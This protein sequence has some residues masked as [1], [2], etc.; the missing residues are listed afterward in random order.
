M[1]TY[2]LF[3]SKISLVALLSMGVVGTACS[4]KITCGEGTSLDGKECVAEEDGAG[5]AGG[6]GS[7][8]VRS[9]GEVTERA[10]DIETVSIEFEGAITAAPSSNTS[11]VVIWGEVSVPDTTF[12]IYVARSEDGFSFSNPQFTAPAGAISFE[13]TGLEKGLPHFIIVRAVIDGTEIENAKTVSVTPEND[14]EAPSFAGI[15]STSSTDG[16]R[17]TLTWDAADDN[18]TPSEAITYLVYMDFE[19]GLG[20]EEKKLVTPFAFSKPGATSIEVTGLPEAATE[21]YFVVRALDAAG[22]LDDNTIEMSGTSGPDVKAPLFAG[23]EIATAKSASSL[24]VFWN[25]ATDDV[26]S[27]DQLVYN[28]YAATTPDGHNFS[29]PDA[30][31]IGGT[32]GVVGDLLKDQK[33]YVV[34][35]AADPSDNTEENLRTA[36]ATTK[37]DDERPV[38]AGIASIENLSSH[39]VDLVWNTASDNQTNEPDLVYKIFIA[40]KS[41][42]QDFEG[43]P[44]AISL[45]GASAVSVTDIDEL[46]VLASDTEY[47][48]VAVAED[49][50]GNQSVPAAETKITTL[51]SLRTDISIPI[52][53]KCTTGCHTGPGDEPVA[54]LRLDVGFEYAALVGID[55][56]TT[57]YVPNS[58]VPGTGFGTASKRVT[59]GDPNASHLIERLN[60]SGFYEGFLMPANDVLLSQEEKDIIARWVTQGAFNN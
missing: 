34:C 8:T 46:N 30:T 26:A 41:G 20:N 21:Y 32:S 57:A 19:A 6:Q 60:A 33:Y 40:T 4:K 7:S 5:G 14:G 29:D 43:A 13:V 3:N 10:V 18:L 50:A 37:D 58:G 55:R 42:E 11:A 38:F 53:Q 52:F 44:S 15:K 56:S 59:P 25:E 35:R 49:L 45:P 24:D 2:R 17:V 39:S 1:K 16:A 22:N 51:V 23:C 28:L 9:T 12:N 54:G 31:V 36:S 27:A 48:M 47:F